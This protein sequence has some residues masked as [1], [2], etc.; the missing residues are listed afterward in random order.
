MKKSV[1]YISVS[2][3]SACT[4]QERSVDLE[5]SPA[6]SMA[7]FCEK[8][9]RSSYAD[10][11]RLEYESA[12][13]EL[14]RVSEGVT[15]IYE[16]YQWQEV[17]SYLIEGQDRALL[18]DT[19]NGIEDIA[20]VV[21]ELTDKP[22]S[23]LNSHSHYDHVGGN[24]QFDRIYGMKTSFS[25]SRQKG[26]EN[27]EIAIE[28]SDAALCKAPPGGATSQTHVGRPY[29]ITHEVSDGSLI[30]LGGRQLEIIHIP[31]HTPDALAL[32]DREARLLWTGDSYYSGPI[33]LYAP[34]TDL[35]AYRQSLDRLIAE[36]EN[37]DA[38]LPA[39]NTP[40]V[41]PDVLLRVRRGFDEMLSGT[42]IKVPQWEGTVI[43][44]LAGEEEFSFLMR[45]EPLPYQTIPEKNRP[46]NNE[47]DTKKPLAE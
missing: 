40:W 26:V 23:V 6:S 13:F 24:Y 14:Y 31:G 16:P 28:L 12:W 37:V 2:L 46:E 41:S 42:A 43:Y 47:A 35:N 19:G 10:L 4:V 18:F 21:N 32:I 1:F 9:P 8:L 20:A 29:T 25:K 7:E 15:A 5:P 3:L 44:E 30:D 34:E 33:W 36:A 11:D 39:H 17:I 38:L 27:Q 45:D 22:I